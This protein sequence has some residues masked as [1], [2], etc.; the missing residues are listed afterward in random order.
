MQPAKVKWIIQG[1]LVALTL[2]AAL[3][4]GKIAGEKKG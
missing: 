4:A 2:A 1:T 3:T